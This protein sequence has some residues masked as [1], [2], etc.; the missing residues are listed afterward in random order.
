VV[1]ED[2]QV[3]SDWELGTM[4][5][6]AVATVHP[7]NPEAV[8]DLAAFLLEEATRMMDPNCK[9]RLQ[10]LGGAVTSK[11]VG[12]SDHAPIWTATAFLDD[13]HQSQAN[14]NSKKHAEMLAASKVLD[15]IPGQSSVIATE[16]REVISA[17]FTLDEW[18]GMKIRS[19]KR[20]EGESWEAWWKRGACDPREAFSRASASHEV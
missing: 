12:G 8:T 5:E 14:G 1:Q 13:I 16:S 10:E 11:R 17:P 3:Y 9:G 7:Y 19:F 18:E 2:F 20:K 15:L 4:V 6:A